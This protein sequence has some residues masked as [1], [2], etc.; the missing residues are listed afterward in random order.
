MR[1]CAAM[2]CAFQNHVACMEI[3]LATIWCK[4]IVSSPKWVTKQSIGQFHSFHLSPSCR[5]Q[6]SRAT[7]HNI[8]RG[9]RYTRE[10]FPRR[11]YRR[12]RNTETMYLLTIISPIRHP[13]RR[14][15]CCN[16]CKTHNE[17]YMASLTYIIGCDTDTRP[18]S[19]TTRTGSWY[20]LDTPHH[21]KD[22]L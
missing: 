3:I 1:A 18:C 21:T 7:S 20:T 11:T 6:S 19:S 10:L 13:Q 14:T 8:T 4:H 22:I 15:P 17:R 5:Q 16:Q 9:C 12:M 2:C